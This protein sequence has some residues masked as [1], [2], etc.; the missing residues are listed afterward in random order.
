MSAPP[1]A[2]LSMLLRVPR[3]A[4][5]ETSVERATAS[6]PIARAIMVEAY[7]AKYRETRSPSAIRW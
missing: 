2:Q 5:S 6:G 4:T 1:I 7:F 3:Y